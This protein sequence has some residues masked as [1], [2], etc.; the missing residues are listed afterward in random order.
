MA[1][2]DA[3]SMDK[4]T[5]VWSTNFCCDVYDQTERRKAASQPNLISTGKRAKKETMDEA[6][7]RKEGKKHKARESTERKEAKQLAIKLQRIRKKQRTIEGLSDEAWL[8]Q[9]PWK[10]LRAA[11]NKHPDE[12]KAPSSVS[13]L[14]VQIRAIWAH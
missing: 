9:L 12:Y 1:A 6:S 14:G 8:E 2:I 5:V 3:R 10:V 13:V 11:V 7:S 4:K